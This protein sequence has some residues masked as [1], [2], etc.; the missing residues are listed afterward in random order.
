MATCLFSVGY[1]AED[2]ARV[3]RNQANIIASATAPTATRGTPNNV[4]SRANEVRPGTPSDSSR[5]TATGDSRAGASAQAGRTAIAREQVGARRTDETEVAATRATATGRSAVNIN[6]NSPLAGESA[7]KAP[8]GG[9]G[10]ASRTAVPGGRQIQP[11]MGATPMSG[12]LRGQQSRSAVLSSRAT[13][14]QA[15]RPGTPS[16]RTARSAVASRE[17][18]PNSPYGKCRTAYFSCMDEFC[19]NR[20]VQFRRC[21]CSTRANDLTKFQQD[22]EAAQG[23]LKD[24]NENLVLVGV[25][26]EQALAAMEASGGEDAFG[27]GDAGTA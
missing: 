1:S 16:A 19:A 5:P 14:P 25:S 17:V 12:A 13:A 26:A 20:D 6:R 23:K 11:M 2:P 4:S 18:N 22:I 24:Y 9:R 27:E 21:A 3:A 7:Q 8:V 15:G 10:A